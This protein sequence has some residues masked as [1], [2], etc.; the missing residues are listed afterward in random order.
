[1]PQGHEAKNVDR[2]L[3]DGRIARLRRIQDAN[4]WVLLPSL[5]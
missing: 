2:F 3:G 1:M 4:K 5:Q